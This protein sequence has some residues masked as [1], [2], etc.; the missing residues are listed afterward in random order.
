MEEL[1]LAPGL[2]GFKLELFPS[3][4]LSSSML[5]SSWRSVHGGKCE[6]KGK[7]DGKGG[8]NSREER[9]VWG[10]VIGPG[11]GKRA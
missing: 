9:E 3:H 4:H 1:E 8:N 6:L 7:E 11:W 10:E 2:P 5:R